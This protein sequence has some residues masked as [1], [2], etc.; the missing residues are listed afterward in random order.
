MA[1][2]TISAVSEYENRAVLTVLSKLRNVGRSLPFDSTYLA[3]DS[4]GNKLLYP[5]LLVAFNAAQTKYV[6]H[7]INGSYGTYS[8][9]LEGIIYTM[10]DFTFEEQIVAPANDCVAVSENCYIY[11]GT[12]GSIPLATRW[13]HSI[14]GTNIQ[15]DE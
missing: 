8:S 6:P 11:G 1:T 9:Y 13:A 12:F 15:W 14:Q 4:Y 10:Y 7:N 2:L 3:A 5:G